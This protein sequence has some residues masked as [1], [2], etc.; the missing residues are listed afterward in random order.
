M[1]PPRSTYKWKTDLRAE[2][3]RSIKVRDIEGYDETKGKWQRNRVVNEPL[4]VGIATYPRNLTWHRPESLWTRFLPSRTVFRSWDHP[5]LVHSSHSPNVL[6]H[7]SVFHED[8]ENPEKTTTSS[9]RETR[10]AFV[11][12]SCTGTV[13]YSMGGTTNDGPWPEVSNYLVSR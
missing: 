10:T 5:S 9:H 4:C 1:P 2:T 13:P 7:E 8:R 11:A 3:K 6:A 12:A